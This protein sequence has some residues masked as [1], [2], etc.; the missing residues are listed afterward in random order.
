MEIVEHVGIAEM[1]YIRY[2]KTMLS[3]NVLAT[4]IKF[5]GSWSML[6]CAAKLL[7]LLLHSHAPPSGLMQ[8]PK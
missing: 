7:A 2:G 4:Q 1:T 5:S 8:M 3:L 6:T